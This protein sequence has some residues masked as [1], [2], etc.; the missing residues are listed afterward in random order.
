MT[1]LALAAVFD[2]GGDVFRP[3]LGSPAWRPCWASKFTRAVEPIPREALFRKVRRV[4]E[5]GFMAVISR[6][7]LETGGGFV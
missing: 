5:S 3:D 1:L 6:N 7:G 4:M 2:H